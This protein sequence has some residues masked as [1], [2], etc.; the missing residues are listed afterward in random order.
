MGWFSKL[1][2]AQQVEDEF[3]EASYT[4]IVSPPAGTMSSKRNIF[5]RFHGSATDELRGLRGGPDEKVRMKL[6]DAFTPAQPV[7]DTRHF[8]GRIG[9]L[10]SL[11]RSLENQRLH[12]VIY[13]ERG[14][15]K[16]SLMRVLKEL[17]EEAQY[18]VRYISCGE[19][20]A[21]QSVIR[22]VVS[23]I[24]MLYHADFDPTDD[25]IE[26]GLSLDSLLPDGNISANE[27]S[28]LFSR[29]SGTRV[30]IMLDEFDRSDKVLFRRQIAELIKNLSDR[31]I[32]VQ[33][34]IAGV[35]G[36]LAEL[37][38]HIPSIRRNVMGLR[39]PA[40]D[41]DEIRDLISIGEKNSGLRYTDL[42]VKLITTFSCGSPYLASLLSQHAGMF[43]IDRSSQTVT[44]Q[45]VADAATVAVEEIEQR[46]SERTI[47]TIRRALAE[48]KEEDLAVL[49]RISMTHGGRLDTSGNDALF[50]VAPDCKSLVDTVGLPYGL[51]VEDG[52]PNE[53]HYRFIEE[54]APNYIWM[55]VACKRVNASTAHVDVAGDLS[56]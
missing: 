43:A 8:A 42:A 54:A 1:F 3:S 47:G 20:S 9:V 46:V 45:D 49:A 16:T 44:P 25:Q 51:V 23:N 55:K 27:V 10:Q 48:G 56:D 33:F 5:P 36:N 22:S 35:A 37:V 2:S 52:D 29:L 24:P 41:A 18:L 11:I 34:I 40:M 38:E 12:V 6:R 50:D 14:I 30:L 39:I 4:E 7:A 31:S 21:F 19:E 26:Q 15:G 32:R 28:D 53:K 17:G 13:G